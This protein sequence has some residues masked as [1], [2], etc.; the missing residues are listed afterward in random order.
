MIEQFF[1]EILQF[2]FPGKVSLAFGILH[3]QS[4]SIILLSL[5][6]IRDKIIAYAVSLAKIAPEIRHYQFP[7]HIFACLLYTSDAA[8]EQYIV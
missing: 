2:I 4:E 3:Q 8:D 5:S 1:G 6:R 7:A